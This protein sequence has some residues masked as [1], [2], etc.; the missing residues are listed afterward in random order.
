MVAH[1]LSRINY[2][3]DRK[4]FIIIE[5]HGWI[6]LN[7]KIRAGRTYLAMVGSRL[8]EFVLEPA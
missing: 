1:A 4:M 3:Y 6:F 2:A 7:K 5:K 8:Y